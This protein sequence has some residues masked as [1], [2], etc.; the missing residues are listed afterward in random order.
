MKSIGWMAA[1][2]IVVS[3]MGCREE[4]LTRA[5]AQEALEEAQLAGQ[6]ATL[7]ASSAD[8]STNFTIGGAVEAAADELRSFIG[9]QLPC[10][11]ITLSAATLT[12]EYGALAGSCTYRGQTYSGTHAISVMRNETSQVVVNHTF[13][14]LS[15]GAISVSG[16]AIVTWSFSNPSRHIEHELVWTRLSDGRQGVGTGDRLQTPLAEGLL[17]GIEIDGTRTWSGESGEWALD[18]DGVQ[19]RWIDLVPQAGTYTLETPFGKT[20]TLSFLRTSPTQIQVTVTNGVD[21]FQFN[22]PTLR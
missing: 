13:S 18:I 16:T 21:E 15:N 9:S 14:E 19:V 22:V 6:A 2:L 17:V 11:Q 3:A 1:G 20:L 5:E 8:L 7:I 10:A 4:R 12:V